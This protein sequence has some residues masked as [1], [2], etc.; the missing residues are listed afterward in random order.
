MKNSR[1]VVLA[2]VVALVGLFFCAPVIYYN[3][4]NKMG[5]A[6]GYESLSCKLLD[7][8][9]S[10]GYHSFLANDRAFMLSCGFAHV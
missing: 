6:S 3:P 9:I 10:Y 2:A 1:I 5:H 4:M 8:G 7:V